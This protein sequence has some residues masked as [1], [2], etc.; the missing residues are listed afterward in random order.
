MAYLADVP[1]NWCPALN[2]VLANEE[3]ADG[4][5]VETGDPVER[6]LMRQWMLR[7]TAYAERLLSDLELLKWPASLKE[8]QRNWIGR[9]EGARLTFNVA[10]SSEA[11]DVFSTRPDTLFGCT[12]CVLAPEH[13]LVERIVSEGQRREVRD[14][15]ASAAR[16][17]ERE[18][19]SEAAIRTGVCTGA[20]A[21]NPVNGRR[22]PI[23]ISDYVL[24]TYGSGAIFGCP[25]HDQR[26][27]EFAKRFGL[28]IIE[29]VVGGNVREAAYSGDGEHISS[30]FL[31]GLD[32]KGGKERILAW[33]EERRFG[34]R[35]VRYALRDWLFSQ[36]RYWGEPIPIIMLEDGAIKPVPES[37]L[38]VLL[39]GVLPAWN[40]GITD[41]APLARATSWV[42]TVDPTTGRPARRETNTMPQW[43]GSSWYFLRFVDPR[44]SNAAWS[45]AAERR[46]MPVDLYI[47][48]A[49]HATLHLLYARFW[50]KVLFDLGYV[51]TPEP[52]RRLFN[53]GMVHSRSYR[54]QR[55]K[56]YY[57]D[58]VIERDGHWYTKEDDRPVETQMEKMSK[59]RNN[60][61]SPEEIVEQ[62]GADSLRIYEVFMGPMEDSVL[63]QTD[64]IVGVRRF[65]D[66]VWRLFSQAG[67]TDITTSADDYMDMER[68]LHKTIRKVT[69]DIEGL[70]LNTAV[71]QTHDLRE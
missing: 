71:S 47:G 40:P 24:A 9:S 7:I 16:R 15:V 58:E 42:A 25:A 17:S 59:S 2:T 11:F 28:P 39:P 37:D 54:D 65:L 21:I 36:Q 43:A 22:L 10:D 49:E 27:Y 51:S 20:D 64:G 38:P 48:G 53:Q 30:E 70:Q 8:M 32:I 33:L 66:R 45:S 56:Y 26:D 60:G 6:R 41:P 31:D 12:F 3:V 1:V 57:P 61:I 50:H 52:F 67:G 44:N 46:W 13:F 18:R 5:Y 35:E 55:G 63:W 19:I 23:W 69:E 62:Y 68:L 4:V 29:V 14:Y 34:K